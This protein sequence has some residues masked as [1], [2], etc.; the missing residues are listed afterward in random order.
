MQY[1]I[2]NQSVKDLPGYE[3][4]CSC[5]R[6]HRVDIHSIQLGHGVIEMLPELLSPF[7][8]RTVLLVS[9]ANTWGIAGER[10]R[11]LLE[12]Q[13]Y[14]VALHR[15]EAETFSSVVPNELALGKLLVAAEE[16]VGVLL[17]VGS[18]TI[19]DICK[20]VAYKIQLPSI[21]VATAP[22]MDGYAS[23]MAPLVLHK[24]KI[25]Y[26][27]QYPYGIVADTDVLKNAPRTMLLAGFGD[28]VGKYTALT[29]WR[30]TTAVN[31]EYYCPVTAELVQ[32]AVDLCVGNVGP[33]LAR[34]EI[35]MERMMESLVLAGIAMGL[36]GISR[37]ASG[38]EHHLAHFWELDALAKGQEHPLHGNSVGAASI[39]TAEAY[40]LM[41]ERFTLIRD[42]N[43]PD[44]AFLRNLYRQAGAAL[45][46][47]DLGIPKDVFRDSVNNG[48]RI[49]PRYTIFNY[50]KDQGLLPWL[51]DA[52][53]DIF[54][55]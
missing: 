46:P 16:D 23:N 51:A 38:S 43:A 22:S 33:Y 20:F 19:N 3:Y 50:T 2:L 44:P 5:G 54:Y 11:D 8:N 53:T 40:R 24:Q 9:D 15:A 13:G 55:S 34:E 39:V 1:D 45:S 30:L 49:R 41:G 42:M 31:Q 28:V 18:G 29:D 4:D 25:T 12:G 36:V 7:R 32:R 48:Y 14:R 17:G 52:V 6:H 10:V 21:I 35:A 27:T 26:K 37:P 47:A